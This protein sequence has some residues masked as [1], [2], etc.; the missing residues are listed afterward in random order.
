M[1]G[2]ELS[3]GLTLRAKRWRPL[4]FYAFKDECGHQK[5]ALS[6]GTLKGTAVECP[7][8]FA[9]FD[10]TTGSLLS[11]PISHACRSPAWTSWAEAMEAIKRTGELLADVEAEDVPTYEVQKEGDTILVRF[12]RDS[13]LNDLHETLGPL[14]PTTPMTG[15]SPCRRTW[16]C[17]ETMSGAD[18]YKRHVS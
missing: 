4:E 3:P 8:H 2:P 18:P 9:R 10:V 6:K 13:G 12:R 11:G 7:L 5:S 16:V 15:A 17:V 1:E 14:G